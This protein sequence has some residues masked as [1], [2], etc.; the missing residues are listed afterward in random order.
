MFRPLLTWLALAGL[1][2][3]QDLRIYHIDVEQADATLFVAP[4]GKTLL[5]DSGK[6]GHGPRIKAV[7]NQA[8]VAQ[9]DFFV[10]THYHE[11]HYGGIDELGGLGVPIGTAFDRGEKNLLSTTKKSEVSF[12]GY[13]SKVGSNAAHLTSGDT[14]ALD[15]GLRVTCVACCG[16]VI[17]ELNPTGG[18]DENDNSVA[19]LVEFGEFAYFVGGDIEE[20]T[21]KKLAA[22]DLVLDVDVYQANHHGSHTS[23]SPEFL[24][25]LRPSVVIISN[26][27]YADYQHPRKVTLA[28]LAALSPQPTVFQTNKYFK[29]G[30]GGNVPDEFI[31]D[32]QSTGTNGTILVTVNPTATQYTVAYRN[33][34]RAFPVKGAGPAGSLVIAS[35]LPDPV[36]S[37]VQNEVVTLRNDSAS[38]VSLAG[39]RLRDAD[40]HFVELGIHGTIAP[41]ATLDIVRNGSRLSLNN[42][43]DTIRLLDADGVTVDEVSYE[44]VALGQVVQGH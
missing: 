24:H 18:A 37:D 33:V 8:G 15:P 7:M 14:I 9:I 29:G 11:D 13:E 44:A 30:K 41:L 23:S 5:V 36:G 31:A 12:I 22:R 1:L 19:L 20:Q 10:C 34:V 3:A 27:N 32:L 17:N 4:G 40:G 16:K 2:C 25:D 43:G 38:P 39:W 28:K 21:E 26:G 35:L 6:N 42:D